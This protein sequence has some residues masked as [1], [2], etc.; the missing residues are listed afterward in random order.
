MSIGRF[1]TE[2]RLRRNLKV[3]ELEDYRD[4]RLPSFRTRRV[5]APTV[6]C[7]AWSGVCKEYAE[8]MQ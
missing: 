7:L 2:D 1:E 8:K 5:E 6:L 4:D 3:K